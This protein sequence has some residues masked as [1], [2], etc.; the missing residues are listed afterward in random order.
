MREIIAEEIKKLAT[1]KNKGK[2][3]RLAKG[4]RKLEQKIAATHR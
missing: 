2:R 3:R 4:W 1:V